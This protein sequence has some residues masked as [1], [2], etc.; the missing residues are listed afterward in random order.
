MHQVEYA[1]RAFLNLPFP[2]IMCAGESQR[3]AC[4]T[5]PWA[6][7]LPQP[8]IQLALPSSLYWALR[9]SRLSAAPPA[10]K[11]EKGGTGAAPCV[12]SRGQGY[13]PIGLSQDPMEGA[14][15][16]DNLNGRD[17]MFLQVFNLLPSG[18]GQAPVFD[19]FEAFLNTDNIQVFAN[20][21]TS[22]IMCLMK[23]VKGLGEWGLLSMPRDTWGTCPGALC[24]ESPGDRRLTAWSEPAAWAVRRWWCVVFP[25]A[26]SLL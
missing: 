17:L 25:G 10:G 7:T 20:A 26:E 19:V 12:P 3:P 1:I 4:F 22:Y 5:T 6:H 18:K 23:F 14:E 24:V 2:I 21:A 13:P 9:I 11:A 8:C 16:M 15:S